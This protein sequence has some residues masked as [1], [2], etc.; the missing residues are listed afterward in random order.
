MT[1]RYKFEECPKDAAEVSRLL[2]EVIFPLFKTY[3]DNEGRR[4]YGKDDT[5]FEFGE[6]N[7]IALMRAWQGG[8]LNILLAYNN[9]VPVGFLLALHHVPLMYN[10]AIL[11]IERC[12][13]PNPTIKQG[14]YELLG[15]LI[16]ILSP[17]EIIIPESDS[18]AA[19][20]YLPVATAKAVQTVTTLRMV[21]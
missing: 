3:W 11:H 12:Y 7:A 16:P 9:D 6:R 5:E 13:A 21:R 19:N 17:D 15:Q 2:G 20:G 1:V 10:A 14:L 18:N 8:L 4:F